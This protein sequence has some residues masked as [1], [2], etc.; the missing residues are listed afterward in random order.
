MRTVVCPELGPLENL[1]I[2]DRQP[3]V[4]GEGQV[5]VQVHAAGV[6]YVDGLM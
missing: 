2:E 1:V 4:P 6:N 3:P 5:V